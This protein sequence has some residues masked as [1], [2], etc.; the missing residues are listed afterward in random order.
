MRN[1]L[2]HPKV[3]FDFNIKSSLDGRTVGTGKIDSAGLFG[4]LDGE[5]S[6]LGVIVGKGHIGVFGRGFGI[7]THPGN[8]AKGLFQLESPGPER[9]VP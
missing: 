8:E 5:Q 2:I 4:N 6:K 3:L 7:V 9:P 1:D